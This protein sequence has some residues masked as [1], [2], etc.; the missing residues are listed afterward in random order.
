M[1]LRC[2]R[3]LAFLSVLFVLPQGFSQTFAPAKLS[4]LTGSNDFAAGDFNHDG[5]L[6][7]VT[8]NAS[9]NQVSIL[10]GNGDG[11]FHPGGV[12]TV[13]GA[14]GLGRLVIRDFNHDGNLDVAV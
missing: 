2:L 7:V 12:Q 4:P 9:T 1:F 11:T 13:P 5:L 10:L 6:D 8:V 14:S 3:L